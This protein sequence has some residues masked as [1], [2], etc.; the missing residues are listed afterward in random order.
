M[1][2]TLPP[3]APANGETPTETAVT[4]RSP[5]RAKESGIG[6][7]LINAHSETVRT[8]NG[9]VF[10]RPLVEALTGDE[11]VALVDKEETRGLFANLEEGRWAG[12]TVFRGDALEHQAFGTGSAIVQGTNVTWSPAS[13][14]STLAGCRLAVPI[15]GPCWRVTANWP[16]TSVSTSRLCH[17]TIFRLL[18]GTWSGLSFLDRAQ[19]RPPFSILRRAALSRSERLS[20]ITQPPGGPWPFGRGAPARWE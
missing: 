16:S 2:E 9:M 19:R 13:A 20:T 10:Q 18:K 11:K 12:L 17:A 15:T 1:L 14:A 7:R 3:L 5:F 4:I 6:C 8:V